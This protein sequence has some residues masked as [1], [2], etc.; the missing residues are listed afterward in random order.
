MRG[1]RDVQHS[2]QLCQAHA[3]PR[4]AVPWLNA[5][6]V[7]IVGLLAIPR[8]AAFGQT[9]QPDRVRVVPEISTAPATGP[10]A[11][12]AGD[13]PRADAVRIERTIPLYV[14]ESRLIDAPWPVARVSVNNPSVADLDIISPQ[15][16][17]LHGVSPGITDF[18]MWSKDER[19]WRARV[20]VELDLRRLEGQL[21]EVFPRSKLE[22]SQVGEVIVISGQLLRAEHALQLRAFLAASKLN[23]LDITSVA[24]LQQVQLKVRVAEVSRTVLR[25]LSSDFAYTDGL[26]GVAVNNA[27]SGTYTPGDVP[28]EAGESV[29]TRSL[30]GGTTIFGTG[31][32]DGNLFELFLQALVDNQYLRLLAEP[33]LV[34]Y[35]GEEANFLAGGEFPVPVVQTGG[36]GESSSQISIEYREF[37]VRLRFKPTVQGDG[38]IRMTCEPEISEL[39]DVG[40][41]QILGTSVPS[42]LTRRISTTF[43]MKTG[44]TFALAG[45]INRSNNARVQRVPVLGLLPVIGTLFR[46]VRYEENETEM[47]VLVTASLVEPQS[48]NIDDVPA[49]GVTHRPPNGWEL[50]LGGKIEGE[51]RANL[52][53]L[54]EERIKELRLDKL[55]GPG[56]WASYEKEPRDG[57]SRRK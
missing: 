27:G 4:R 25:S 10:A 17:Q 34:A 35:S 51:A 3:A 16:V 14:G 15:Q 53:P 9:T 5:L 6:I 41:I 57:S 43:E 21:A 49:P 28:P 12:A 37:G 30:P 11:E 8:P 46:S 7:M 55:H 22:V 48:V 45:L 1:N 47:V 44:Q 31:T 2:I 36:S 18:T 33:T 20:E 38:T 40:A 52:P 29:F 50:F 32:I 42:L 23:F 13:R 39:S 54:T 56:T 26:R 19:V 24:G